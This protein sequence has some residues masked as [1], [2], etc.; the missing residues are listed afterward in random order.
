[1][2][3]GQH[4]NDPSSPDFGVSPFNGPLDFGDAGYATPFN[5]VLVDGIIHIN[6]PEPG[7]IVLFALASL[8]FVVR[9]VACLRSKNDLAMAQRKA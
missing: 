1:L 4:Y 2:S 9:G 3:I 8:M 5:A 7:S 6:V